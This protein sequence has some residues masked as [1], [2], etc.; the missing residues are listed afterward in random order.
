MVAV[1]DQSRSKVHDVPALFPMDSPQARRLHRVLGMPDVTRSVSNH[2]A[3]AAQRGRPAA[4]LCRGNRAKVQNAGSQAPS[5][6]LSNL[7]CR[8][9]R[10]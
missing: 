10:R 4:A 5:R 2:G 9:K 3:F 1:K 8:K 7:F 6:R